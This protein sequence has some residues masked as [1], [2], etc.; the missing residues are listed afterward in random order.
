MRIAWNLLGRDL[1]RQLHYV[2]PSEVQDFDMG[3][4]PTCA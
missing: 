3:P 2:L 1:E 4:F